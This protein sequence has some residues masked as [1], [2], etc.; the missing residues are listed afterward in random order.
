MDSSRPE[1][2]VGGNIEQLPNEILQMVPLPD[3]RT[4]NATYNDHRYA[5][6]RL[7]RT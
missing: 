7:G 4:L 2:L 5:E 6:S 1:S 3:I